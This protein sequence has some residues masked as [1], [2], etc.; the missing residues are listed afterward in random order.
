MS[1]LKK[2]T[3]IYIVSI[4]MSLLLL[5]SY[6]N[7][8]LE[9]TAI[10]Q[11]I[12]SKKSS[13]YN[14]S[15]WIDGIIEQSK[16]RLI[17]ISE[18]AVFQISPDKSLIVKDLN[19]IPENVD[20]ERRQLLKQLINEAAY[21]FTVLFV[22]L[23]NG[24]HYISHP[25]SVQTSL[26]NYNLSHRPYFKQA[27]ISK[28]IIL[29]DT[30]VGADGISAVAIDIPIVN[31]KKQILAHLGGVFHLRKLSHLIQNRL[32]N[33]EGE[34]SFLMDR[35]GHIIT[36][37]GG[38]HDIE[39]RIAKI[40]LVK[41]FLNNNFSLPESKDYPTL[42]KIIPSSDQ[43]DKQIIFLSRL[44]SG[45]VLGKIQTMSFVTEKF[46]QGI[47]N[48]IILAATVLLIISGI[49]IFLAHRIGH[50][51]QDAEH[52]LEQAKQ[53]LELKVLERTNKLAENELL[54]DAI[55]NQSIEGI[56]VADIDGN[57]S[58]VNDA[59]CQMLGYSR[60]ELLTMSVFDVKAPAQNTL[61]FEQSK[62]SKEGVP[63]RVLLQRKDKSIFMSEVIGKGIKIGGI[64]H[65]LGVVRDISDLLVKEQNIR[66]LSQAVEQ[67]PMSII[68]TNTIGD[69]E[70]VNQYFEETTGYTLEEVKGKNPR[71]LKSG[72]TPLMIYQ[73]LWNA[74][75][76]GKTWKGEMQNRKK[77]GD[78]FW[79]YGHFAP[80]TDD[81]GFVKH[82]LA[83][84]QDISI[85][86]QQLEKIA[87]Q[88]HYDALT[89]LPNRFLSLDRL[90]YLLLESQRH[91]HQVAVLFL[92][93][94]DFKKINDTLGHATGDRLL[95]EVALRLT[96]V[97]RSEDT[98]GRLGG[99]EFLIL[100]GGLK[101]ASEAG[102]VAKVILKCLT[103]TF[104][105]DGRKLFLSASIGIAIAPDDGDIPTDLLRDADAAMYHA[106]SLGRNTYSY[107]TD[108]MNKN[109]KRKLALEE[110]IQGAVKRNEFTVFY[111]PQFDM[112]TGKI[113]G[114]EA[115]LRWFN[116]TLGNI[117]PDEFIPIAEH[118]G[119]ITSI[120]QFVLREALYQTA[121]WQKKYNDQFRIAVNLSPIQFRD[122]KL[123][124]LIKNILNQSDVLS[125]TLELEITEG[126]LMSGH[127]SIDVALSKF[128]QS[129]IKL[130]MDDFGTGY[131]SLSY[132][133]NYPFNVLKID[134]CFIDDLITDPSDRELIIASIAMAH[135]LN[136]K[137]VAEG[138]ETQEQYDEL[139]KLGCDYAQ[140]YLLG[141]PVPANEMDNFFRL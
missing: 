12:E 137:V 119:I 13:S 52:D 69:I 103:K 98:V 86:K 93:L 121:V 16:K 81:H 48:T 27:T 43:N 66:T 132:L 59:F 32:L 95:I 88:A 10:E 67:T 141:K 140:G 120:G 5:T 74:I 35:S 116:P 61:S 113:M 19:G 33:D 128:S 63:I 22:L 51:W 134:K 6:L 90:S 1:P 84:K 89:D 71:I 64:G 18:H 118:T 68:I 104:R 70:Y 82:Y 122:D 54:L 30:F 17:Q 99:D 80:V 102:Q 44:Q 75:T 47:F 106:K 28:E 87:H 130:A 135:G 56:S 131:S 129:G 127:K 96:S 41:N 139:K 21:G 65:V 31:E 94:D 79:E 133:R 29:S 11:W 2:I 125:N 24:D 100:L 117:T 114:A 76:M 77:N 26:Q 60:K 73:E 3:L 55:T 62:S 126:V 72:E 110:Q 83:I 58:F 49:G 57:Y 4:F 53:Y 25:F 91:H 105:V 42:A 38:E 111:Q 78:I 124:D 20:V 107:F 39:E 92:D 8:S 46:S 15:Y 109:L 9:D 101:Q 108:K 115:L 14:M 36:Q 45:W 7:N 112:H 50:R 37:N 123:V 136:I 23:P 97:I 34:I 138:V 85:Q 40:P